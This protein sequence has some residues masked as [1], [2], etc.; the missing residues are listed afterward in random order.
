MGQNALTAFAEK[1][2]LAP[3]QFKAFCQKI[4]HEGPATTL[5]RTVQCK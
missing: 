2:C 1:T 3:A 4:G 5:P